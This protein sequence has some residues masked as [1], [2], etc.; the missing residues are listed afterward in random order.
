MGTD[1]GAVLYRLVT[2]FGLARSDM[3]NRLKL[4]KTVY[5]LQSC[6]LRL[7]YGFSWY[8][9]GPYSQ[10]LVYDAYRVLHAESQKYARQAKSLAFSENTQAWLGRFKQTLGAALSDAKQLELL[11]S[12]SFVDKTWRPGDAEFV[13]AFKEHKKC[14]FDRTPIP[15]HQIKAARKKLAELQ[16][17]LSSRQVP[18]RA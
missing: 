1:T 2:E 3:E 15:D 8:R 17:A 18:G 5:L 10:E 12:V 11:A 13:R 9:Y 7:G 6:G 14:F 4:Q 16:T